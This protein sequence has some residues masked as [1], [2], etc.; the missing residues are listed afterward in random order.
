MKPEIGLGESIPKQGRAGPFS[1]CP[2]ELTLR[3]ETKGYYGRPIV[4]TES[5][6]AII[7]AI[8][9]YKVLSK[10]QIS[11]LTGFRR[12]TEQG[13]TVL[14][15]LGYVDRLVTDHTPPLYCAGPAMKAR[16]GLP[17]ER[18]VLPDTFRVVAANQ[19]FAQLSAQK[20]PYDCDILIGPGITAILRMNEREYTILAPREEPSEVDWC[21]TCIGALK[22]S[23]RVIVVAGSKETAT[24]IASDL[25]SRIAPPIRYTWDEALKDDIRFYKYAGRFE[26]EMGFGRAQV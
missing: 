11:L 23:T 20:K 19:L 16:F 22:L 14:H 2:P 21:L 6:V 1:A 4:T 8:R 10:Y 25:Y 3:R 17:A 24:E 13:L 5:G 26:E 18:W 7:N 15:S 9:K 12:A